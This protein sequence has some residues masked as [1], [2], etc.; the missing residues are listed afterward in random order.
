[1]KWPIILCAVSVTVQML[2]GVKDCHA[3]SLYRNEAGHFSM[4]VPEGWQEL[5]QSDLRE[6]TEHADSVNEIRPLAIFQRQ[7]GEGYSRIDVSVH[8][9]GRVSESELQEFVDGNKESQEGPVLEPD[10]GS[11]EKA[12]NLFQRLEA[13]VFF[14]DQ[15][16]NILLLRHQSALKGKKNIV[17]VNAEFFSNYGYVVVT[18]YGLQSDIENYYE[19]FDRMLDSFRFDPGYQY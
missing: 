16:R 14:Y 3:E 5:S 1:M 2:I 4:I 13:D 18:L 17:A 15:T 12:K 11:G 19:D 10:S 7:I 8:D 6:I 9:V